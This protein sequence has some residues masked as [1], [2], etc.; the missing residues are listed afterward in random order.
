MPKRMVDGDK[1]WASDKIGQ[2][3]PESFRSEYAN[4]LP[5]ALANGSFECSPR[6]IWR[7]VYFYNRPSFLESWVEH[8]LNE[9]ERVRLLFR[10]KELDGKVWGFW[11][12]IT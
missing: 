11:I 10:W 4:L 12:G 8:L 9:L 2:I 5:L 6:R 1:I 7:D 3:Q